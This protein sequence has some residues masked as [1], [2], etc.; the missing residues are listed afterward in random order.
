[1]VHELKSKYDKLFDDIF[2]DSKFTD[3]I[4]QECGYCPRGLTIDTE[5]NDNKPEFTCR[6]KI[7]GYEYSNERVIGDYTIIKPT[8]ELEKYAYKMM[9]YLQKNHPELYADIMKYDIYFD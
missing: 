7:Y 2:F 9:E 3:F 8:V 5:V 6:L 4:V 1:M